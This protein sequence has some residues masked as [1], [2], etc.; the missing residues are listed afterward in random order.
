MSG[1]CVQEGKINKYLFCNNMYILQ[2]LSL[3]HR[4]VKHVHIVTHT[5]TP[6]HA[7][8]WFT[9]CTFLSVF[10]VLGDAEVVL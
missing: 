6:T 4:S 8:F 5:T 3:T 1:R 2:T 9:G 10:G 7:P